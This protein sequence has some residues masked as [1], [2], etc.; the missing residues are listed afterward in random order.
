MAA[1]PRN[2]GSAN[3]KTS[4][5]VERPRSSRIEFGYG[6]L[7]KKE[8]TGHR[9]QNCRTAPASRDKEVRGM[10]KSMRPQLSRR[11][12]GER[13]GYLN[14]ALVFPDC[15]LS[16]GC[17]IFAVHLSVLDRTAFLRYVKAITFTFVSY[18]A[19]AEM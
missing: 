8:A 15:A 16:F 11:Q 10:R 12:I 1:R 5:P 9:I 4:I 13:W 18:I 6:R 7:G 3:R 14:G 19:E 2:S 17:K